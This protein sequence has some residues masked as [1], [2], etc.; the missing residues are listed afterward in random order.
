M[1]NWKRWQKHNSGQTNQEPLPMSQPSKPIDPW[2]LD[3]PLCYFSSHD[4]WTTRMACSGTAVLGETGS[5]K[6]S[7]SGV[8]IARSFLR[9]GF[10]GLILCAKPE[11]RK[12][13]QVLA[14][15][16]GRESHLV[17]VGEN[18]PWRLNFLQYEQERQSRG[19]G[20]IENLLELLM[21]AGEFS[22]EK[23][24]G[25]DGDFFSLSSREMTRS[26]ISALVL[27]KEPLSM[28]AIKRMINEAPQSLE[29]AK[30][31]EWQQ[32]SY[33]FH[34]L[35]QGMEN[36][37]TPLEK[38]DWQTTA[39][40][41]TQQF[42]T[43]ADRTRSS[44]VATYTSKIDPLTKGIAHQ[45]FGTDINIV[46]EAT[47]KNGALIIVDLPL[48]EYFAVG[49]ICQGLF[50]YLFQR[51]LLQRNTEAYPRPVF[52]W[53][54]ESQFFLSPGDDYRFQTVARSARVCTV[55][56]SQSVSGYYALM[57]GD[58]RDEVA[59]L[60]TNLTTKIFHAN[61]DAQ[62]NQY[63]ADLIGKRWRTIYNYS[64]S[65]SMQQAASVNSSAGGSQQLV[66]AVD[67][68]EFTRL[69]KGGPENNLEVDA[70]IYQGGRTWAA[71]GETYLR[72]TFKQG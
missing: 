12:I 18:Q 33:C 46:P 70:I 16:T 67:P 13:W 29:E 27:A 7:G 36:A 19:G 9:A 48:A 6:S 24:G 20:Q 35:Q 71:S 50:K 14:K 54:D 43:T 57:K 4:P 61:S 51:A 66:Y 63:A 5:G 17:I 69:R 39:T 52:L 25:D 21:K 15:E 31:E 53:A 59:S 58:G 10:G 22:G 1:F 8:A 64:S 65:R 49:R 44:V 38:H 28:K 40:Y 11:E 41:W 30:S 68:S 2:D 60:L 47:Y 32:S 23:Q 62:T 3:Q 34:I 42:A 37:S 56:L 26:A 72:T 45:L 55:L